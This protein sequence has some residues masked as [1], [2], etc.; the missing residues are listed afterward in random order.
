MR[1][2]IAH[3]DKKIDTDIDIPPLQSAVLAR[4]LILVFY[5]AESSRLRW[6]L[7]VDVIESFLTM[8]TM[9]SLRVSVL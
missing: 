5:P 6:H 9:C 3:F 8:N 7:D 4:K 2:S 1:P